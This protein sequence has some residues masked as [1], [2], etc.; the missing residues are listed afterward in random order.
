[1]RSKFE[2]YFCYKF[3]IRFSP[4]KKKV[5]KE[6]EA[7]IVIFFFCE[8][9]EYACRKETSKYIYNKNKFA[10]KAFFVCFKIEN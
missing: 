6:K 10:A 3:S 1:M 9:A 7:F 8:I 4:V 2:E 5:Y